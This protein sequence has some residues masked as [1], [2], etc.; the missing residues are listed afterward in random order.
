MVQGMAFDRHVLAAVDIE[1]EVATAL[2][3]DQAEVVV[4]L[5]DIC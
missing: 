4:G 1:A 3:L 2:D 5:A